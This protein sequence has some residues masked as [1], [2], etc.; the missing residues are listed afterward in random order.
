MPRKE[1]VDLNDIQGQYFSFNHITMIVQ[2]KAYTH[3]W[4][5][6]VLSRVLEFVS[7]IP[8]YQLILHVI[9]QFITYVWAK[10]I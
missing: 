2:T 5:F 3:S 6:F 1:S 7:F 9:V 10:P 8:T 4:R